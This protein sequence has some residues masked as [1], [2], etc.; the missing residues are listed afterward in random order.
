[1]LTGQLIYRHKASKYIRASITVVYSDL[2][3]A[4]TKQRL[5][6]PPL[7]KLK[8]PMHICLKHNLNYHSPRPRLEL[9]AVKLNLTAVKL[10]LTAVKP[11][12]TAVKTNLTAAKDR[13]CRR[14][15]LPAASD[16]NKQIM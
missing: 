4:P 13:R 15:P 5:V 6:T 9:T 3:I 10:N 8:L 7:I 14:Q 1:M 16:K 11:S 2:E 12:L